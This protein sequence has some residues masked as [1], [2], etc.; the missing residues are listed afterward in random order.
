MDSLAQRLTA[1]ARTVWPQLSAVITG[2]RDAFACI[3]GELLDG[4][5]TKLCQHG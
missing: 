4:E 2:S 1:G 3:D 5:I